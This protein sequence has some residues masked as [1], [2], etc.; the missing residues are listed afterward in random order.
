MR[1][2][3]RSL[4][5]F[6][7]CL[8]LF[9]LAL[10]M[11][12]AW[13]TSAHEGENHEA[14]DQTSSSLQNKG[15]D[16]HPHTDAQAHVSGK[17]HGPESKSWAVVQVMGRFHPLVV[18]FPI[19]LILVAAGW[20]I[21]T[22]CFKGRGNSEFAFSA[23]AIGFASSVVAA[24]FGWAAGADAHHSA[25]LGGASLLELH[26]WV[27]TAIVPLSGIALFIGR[28][29]RRSK[30]RAAQVAYVFVLSVSALFVGVAG[31]FGAALVHGLDHLIN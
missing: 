7:C 27:G 15:S 5:K 22:F 9:T 16:A 12:P 6:K 18:H 23:L 29:A 8:P 13:S 4:R 14:E 3:E 2:D 19:A 25:Q 1:R 31:F 28:R 21:V 26:R 20:E 11:V 24:G 10:F 17:E 30:T